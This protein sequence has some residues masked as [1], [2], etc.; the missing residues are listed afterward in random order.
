MII[1]EK[2]CDLCHGFPQHLNSRQINHPEMIRLL[3]V[4]SAS[5]DQQNSFIPQ[6]IQGKLFIISNVEF[7]HIDLREKIKGSLRLH[8]S[9]SGNVGQGPVNVLSLLINPA[10]RHQ[11]AVDALMASQGRLDDGLGRHIGTESILTPS[12]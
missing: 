8:G 10:A 7:L 1:A 2:V 6:K 9:D 5:V 12:I 3:P 4:E 11:V